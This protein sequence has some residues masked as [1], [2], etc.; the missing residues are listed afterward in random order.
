MAGSGFSYKASYGYMGDPQAGAMQAQEE[1]DRT[2]HLTPE[3]YSS[4]ILQPEF[5]PRTVASPR[6]QCPGFRVGGESHSRIIPIVQCL[7]GLGLEF[8]MARGIF[9]V[10][11]RKFNISRLRTLEADQLQVL[12]LRSFELGVNNSS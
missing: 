8:R 11:F 10:E 9:G 6:P 1:N 5:L 4:Q 12:C 2:R 7:M 3:D